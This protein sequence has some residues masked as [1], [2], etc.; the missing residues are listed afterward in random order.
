[1]G[2]DDVGPRPHTGG[3]Q[4]QSKKHKL[5]HGASFL[6]SGGC[7]CLFGIRTVFGCSAVCSHAI[8]LAAVGFVFS[9]TTKSTQPATILATRLPH[10][11][12]LL[13]LWATDFLEVLSVLPLTVWQTLDWMVKHYARLNE[14][15]K[16]KRLFL[17]SKPLM[18][19]RSSSNV[20]FSFFSCQQV[21]S[22]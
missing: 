12:L 22:N 16:A 7:G 13:R 21:L 17:S 3:M 10:S 20:F 9:S 18:V 15:G 6:G 4:S 8:N 11:V 19:S 2:Q 1:M 5:K 14:N